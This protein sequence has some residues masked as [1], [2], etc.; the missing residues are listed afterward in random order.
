MLHEAAKAPLDRIK[1]RTRTQPKIACLM[2]ETLISSSR[3]INFDHLTKTK[4]IGDII[5]GMN[6][7]SLSDILNLIESMISNPGRYNLEATESD[8]V[9]R[10]FANMLLTLTRGRNVDME[11][12][13][14]GH[15]LRILLELSYFDGPLSSQIAAASRDTFRSRLMS[16]INHMISSE[17]EAS[18]ACYTLISNLKTMREAPEFAAVL[19]ADGSIQR[20]L[21]HA[22]RTVAD[23]DHN[24]RSGEARGAQVSQQL[25][26]FLT[27]L[28]AIVVA[29]SECICLFVCSDNTSSI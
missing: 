3:L 19:K 2:V 21:K 27:R 25:F 12:A 17:S 23:I 29:N 28:T 15:M 5:N 13:W 1:T 26:D 20:S 10:T 11:E 7:Q 24:R 4:T 8:V 6:A 18:K 14:M 16:C 9:A 22:I